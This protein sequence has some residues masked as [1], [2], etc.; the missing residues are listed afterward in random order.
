MSYDQF[1]AQQTVSRGSAVSYDEG[2]RA[3]MQ[4]VYNR[5]TTG[6]LVTGIV[7]W[8]VG[9]S[10]ALLSF[11]FSGP[12][13]WIVML[14]PLAVVMF[15]FRPDRM[16]PAQLQLSFIVLSVLYGIS[17]GTIFAVFTDASIAQVFFMATALFAGLSIFGYVTKK[18]LSG[19]GTFLVMAMIGLLVVSLGTAGA[20]AFGMNVSGLQPIIAGAGLLIFSGL[21]AYET[22][23][24]KE[25]YHASHGDDANSRMA[26]AAALNLYV[27]FIAI[28]Q[29]L[30]QFMGQRE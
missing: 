1:N 4:R 5:M 10:P 12:Q 8:F 3:H 7:S 13:K 18:N 22:Q 21:T 11:F 26:W 17:F 27:S 19:M 29:Y 6:V 20:A 2:L 9:N 28:F 14:A 16:S 30:L 25:M 15:G 24:T 23:Q